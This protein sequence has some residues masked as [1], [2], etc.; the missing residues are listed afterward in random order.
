MPHLPV[1][2]ALIGALLALAPEPPKSPERIC[3]GDDKVK[4]CITIVPPGSCGPSA[5]EHC[6]DAACWCGPADALRWPGDDGT[7]WPLI[8]REAM[9]QGHECATGRQGDRTIGGCRVAGWVCD[10]D[11]WCQDSANRAWWADRSRS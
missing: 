6:D 1:I 9:E 5:G 4:W 10:G 8:A 7:G 3:G 2:G 11:G